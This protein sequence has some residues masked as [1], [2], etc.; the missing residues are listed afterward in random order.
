M[1]NPIA[2]EADERLYGAI[3]RLTVN[4]ARLEAVLDTTMLIFH[5][6]FGNS[7]NERE[8]PVSLSRKLTYLRKA[9]KRF[10]PEDVATQYLA[11][12]DDIQAE[13]DTRHD[14][15]HG[16]A[17]NLLET[18]GSFNSI[19]LINKR[20][21][22]ELKPLTVTTDFVIDAL[23]RCQALQERLMPWPLAI[24]NAVYE[25]RQQEEQRKE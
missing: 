9:F 12:F 1:S 18:P 15:V 24:A 25:R 13:S 8:L 21:G 6:M 23:L 19:R 16:V 17:V 22:Y 20:S 3:G 4:W 7:E 2:T 11:I 5:E 10:Q 14:M